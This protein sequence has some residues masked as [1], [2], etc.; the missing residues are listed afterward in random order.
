[1]FFN[2]DYCYNLLLSNLIYCVT[3]VNIKYEIKIDNEIHFDYTDK[4]KI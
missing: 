2:Y 4:Y 1:M 3:L